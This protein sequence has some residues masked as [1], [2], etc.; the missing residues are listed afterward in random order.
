M[1]A[2][3]LNVLFLRTG[4]S[5]RAILAEAILNLFGSAKFRAFSAGSQPN[6]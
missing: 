2:R 6:G 3:H 5:A 4:N 1:T